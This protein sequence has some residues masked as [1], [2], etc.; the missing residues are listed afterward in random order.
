MLICLAN[1]AP[2][3]AHGDE[4]TVG[5]GAKGPVQLSPAQQKAI[6]LQVAPAELRPLAELLHLNGEVRLLPGRQ[7]TVST[8][9][10]GQVTALFA[11]LGDTVTAG[12][13]LVRVQSRLVGDPPPSV[14]VTAPMTGV[15]DAVN[16][17]I[18]QSVEPTTVLITISNRS[19]VN[20]V[21]RVY[22]EDLGK[23]QKGQEATIHTL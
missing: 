21:A 18:G 16:V 11:N 6:D 20:V 13:R 17:A 7:A 4:V 5:A 12:Q 9:I 8:R 10:S 1:V 15:V 2:V 19:E 3:F 22:E 23:V 14:D